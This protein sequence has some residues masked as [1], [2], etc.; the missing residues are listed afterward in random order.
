MTNRACLAIL[1]LLTSSACALIEAPPPRTT[2]RDVVMDEALAQLDRP[3]RNEGAD[4]TGFDAG[5]LVQYVFRRSGVE[6]PHSIEGQHALGAVVALSEMR[7]GDLV[8]YELEERPFAPMHVG[9][10]VGRSRMVHILENGRVK[11]DI[12]D[13][14]YW[15][16]RLLD[17]VSCLP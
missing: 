15:H 16:R 6:L 9:I 7:R 10:Y 4:P 8:F 12:I 1:L 5:G 2:T 17:V 11:L 13:T 3:Y 14:P